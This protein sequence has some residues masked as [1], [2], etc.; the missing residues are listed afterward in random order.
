MGGANGG[1][2]KT[3]DTL[4]YLHPTQPPPPP[5]SP[6]TFES[7]KICSL[8]IYVIIFHYILGP[9]I[10]FWTKNAH[11]AIKEHICSAKGTSTTLTSRYQVANWYSRFLGK[12][13]KTRLK[14][15]I[16]KFITKFWSLTWFSCLYFSSKIYKKGLSWSKS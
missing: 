2:N 9:S 13:Q 1:A 10:E 12:I 4:L 6:R 5:P 14:V 11:V 7:C 15:D 3:I 8:A 16:K